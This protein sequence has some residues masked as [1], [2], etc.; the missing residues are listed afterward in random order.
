MIYIGIGALG[1]VM[2][3]IFDIVSL[4]R[5]PRVKPYIWALGC[6]L[7]TYSLIK[8]CLAPDKLLLPV[9]LTWLGWGVL[10]VSLPL[11]IYSLFINLPLRKTYVTNGV[12]DKLI[13]TGQYAL[14]RHPGV[15]WFTL[16]MLSLIPVSRSSLLLI[17]SPT[18]ILLDI[19][20]IVIQDKFVLSRMFDRYDSYRKETPM[21]LPNKR[22]ISAFIRCLRQAGS[23]Q[24]EQR[25]LE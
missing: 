5:T 10:A 8:I 1:F 2:T 4:K 13:T 3:H 21:L 6:G 22:S 16:L 12:G 15:I 17:A 19:V 14:V 20:L 18:F 24:S 25:R 7:L 11:L 9:W 23:R